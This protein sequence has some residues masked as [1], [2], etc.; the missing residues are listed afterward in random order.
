MTFI[1]KIKRGEYTYLAEVKN[2]WEK[3]KVRQKH[4]RYVGKEVDGKQKLSGSIADAQIDRVSIYGPLLILNA[5]ARE[6]NLSNLLG[7]YGEYL[8]SLAYA[9][10]VA[11]NSVKKLTDWFERTDIHSL[12]DIP[13]VTYKKLLEALDSVGGGN[14]IW[15]QNKIFRAIK[16]QF[17]LEPEGYFYDIT[18]VYFYGIKCPIAKKKKKLE[19]KN[20]PQIQIGLAVTKED[21][22]PIFHRVFEGNIFDS[23]TL[24]EI[25]VAFRDH[26]VG[27]AFLVWDR[28]VSSELN[29]SDARKAGFHVLCGLALKGDMKKFARKTVVEEKLN[30]IKNRV[31]LRNAIFYAKKC[32]CEYLGN[33]GYLIVCLNEKQ[34]QQI[35]EKRYDNLEKAQ[36]QI[37]KNNVHDQKVKKFFKGKKLDNS[38]VEEAEILDGVSAIF[39]SKN[40]PIKEFVR[41]YFEKDKVEKVFRTMKG[42]LEMDKIRFWLTGKV[43]AHIFICY[44]SYLLLSLMDFK[45][46]NTDTSAINA[47]D[48]MGTMYK[49]FI[50]DSKT[51]NKFVKTVTL[52]EQQEKI[53]KA[54]DKNL[55]KPSVHNRRKS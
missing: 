53:L 7:E 50:T 16:E 24:Q 36:E 6:A 5:V 2:V 38:A 22:I 54:V 8:L 11:P 45:L 42:L 37:E 49:L 31:R 10:C 20:L 17:S 52:T 28:G 46:K 47:I 9:H 19:S 41:G 15:I 33:K 51:K 32:P 55:L 29:I 40:L 48:I 1:R 39:C 21:A 25:L 12:L 30:S 26:D 4:I 34:R 44:L 27:N 23:K 43:K 18:N 3:G 14:G 35:R 13:D